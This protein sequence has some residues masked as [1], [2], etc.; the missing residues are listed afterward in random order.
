MNAPARYPKMSSALLTAVAAVGFSF[1]AVSDARAQQSPGQEKVVHLMGLTGVKDNA[2][3][4][5]T[6]ES[7]RLHFVHGKTSAEIGATSIEDVLTG[8]DSRKTVG[9]TVGLV[10]MAAPYGGGRFLSLFRTKIDTLTIQYREANRS[11]HGVIFTMPAGT[12]EG[13]KK[14]LVAQGART[15]FPGENT[16][17]KDTPANKEQTQ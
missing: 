5:L 9:K 13:I 14:Q 15:T 6:V 2:K 11:L 7:G 12:A 1:F 3:G 10:S 17:S 4:T 8:I 16:N